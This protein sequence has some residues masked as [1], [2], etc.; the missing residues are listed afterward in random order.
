MATLTGLERP[1]QS[2]SG[3]RCASTDRSIVEE[4][5]CSDKSLIT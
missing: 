4:R 3:S 1:E 2:R 5:P